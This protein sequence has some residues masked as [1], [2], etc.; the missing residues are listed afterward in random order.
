MTDTQPLIPATQYLRM[1]TERQEYSFANQ[2]AAIHAY[3]ARMGFV[4]STTYSDAGKSGLALKCREGLK[5]LLNDVV[6]GQARFKAILVYDVSRWGRFQDADE[7]A[8]YEFLCKAAGIR[9]HYCAEQFPNDTSLGSSMMKALKRVMAGEYSRELSETVHLGEKRV[10]ENGFRTGGVPGYGLRRMLVSA[11]RDPKF[12]LS[13]GEKKCIQSDHVILVPGAASEVECVRNIFQMFTKENKWPA[14]IARELRRRGIHYHGKTRTEWYAMAVNRLLKNP[15][16]CGCSVFGQS[17]HRLR[18]RRILHSRRL[19]T[20]TQGAWEPII[21]EATFRDAQDRF[22][23]QTIHKRDDELLSSLRSLLSE[24][25][26]LSE[27]LLNASSRLPSAEPFVRRF[28]SMSEAFEKVGFVGPRLLATKTK[29][30]RHTLRDRIIAEIV[31]GDPKHI[32]VVH[33]DGHFRPRLRVFGSSVSIFLCGCY[34]DREGEQRWVF[35]A[36]QRECK[37]AALVVLLNRSNDGITHLFLVPDT[38]S[39]IRFTLKVGDPWLKRGQR[40]ESLSDFL[41]AFQL[42]RKADI[43]HVPIERSKQTNTPLRPT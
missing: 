20:I 14:A 27:K 31:T 15:K 32:A 34:Q 6:S 25:G 36:V 24:Q 23:S 16:Y 43:R 10:S 42:A 12:L 1:S 26:K 40:L 18:T 5:R 29:R 41:P 7:S 30:L 28:G 11:N 17:E 22:E 19:W 39:R 37:F 21:D 33:K 8:H 13:T 38:R 35:N 3:A 9:V 2:I 4:V